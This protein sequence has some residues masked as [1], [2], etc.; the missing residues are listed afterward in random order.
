M[1]L[2]EIVDWPLSLAKLAVIALLEVIFI[3]GDCLSSSHLDC[4]S[5]ALLPRIATNSQHLI[6]AISQFHYIL[7]ITLNLVF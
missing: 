1:M 5:G 7:Y 2:S 3:V 6:S 4:E